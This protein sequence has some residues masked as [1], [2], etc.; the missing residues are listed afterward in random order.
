MLSGWRILDLTDH[1]GEVGP[2]LLADL[3]AEVVKVEPQGGCPSRAIGPAEV[4]FSAYNGNKHSIELSGDRTVDRHRLVELLTSVDVVVESGPPGLLAEHGLDRADIVGANPHIVSVI[5]TP[6]GRSGPRAD[7]P[8]TELTI[9][10]LG[11]SIRLQ[12]TRERAPVQMSVPQVWRHAG[13]EAAVAAMVASRRMTTT[14][15]PQFVDVSAQSAMTWT[16]LNAMEAY[17]VQGQEFE[18]NGSELHLSI[19]VQL[20]IEA[21]DGYVVGVPTGRTLQH[22]APWLVEEGI[23]G[24]EWADVDWAT[25]DHRVIAG[26]PTTH[27]MAEVADAIYTL[28]RRYP[29]WELFRRSLSYGASLAPLNTLTDLLGFDHLDAR[30]FWQPGDASNGDSD[31]ARN[32]GAFYCRNGLRPPVRRGRTELDGAPDETRAP[33]RLPTDGPD[34]AP[35]RR[36]GANGESRE[37]ELPLAGVKVVDFSWIGVGPITAKSLADHGATV[38]RVESENRLDGLRMQPPYVGGESGL[39]RSNFFGTFNTSKL[40]LSLDLKT[41]AGIDVARRL[42]GWADVVVESFTPGTFDRLGLGYAEMSAAHPSLI[43]VSTSMLGAGSPASTMAGYGYHAAAIAGF[44]NLVGWPDLPPDG[45]WLAYTDTIG[46]RFITTALLAALDHRRRTGEGSHLEAAQLEVALQLL[47]PELAEFQL[48]GDEPRRRGNRDPRMAPQGVYPVR[49]DDEWLA[50]S[51]VDDDAWRRFVDVLG[52]PAW[53]LD[54]AL[55]TAAGRQ[56]HHDRIDAHLTEWTA[57]RD[58]PEAEQL[59]RDYGIAAGVVQSSRQLSD[60]P[61]YHHRRFYHYLEH[62]EVGV[63][64]YAGH[65]YRI[66]GYDHGPRHAA[67]CLGEHTYEVLT[68]LLGLDPDEV[69]AIAAADALL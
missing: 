22:I 52:R 7:Q 54:P 48:T 64:P 61:Q 44:Q 34:R 37:P 49:G 50:V 40:G 18:R 20:R 67:P 29:K 39:N 46:P 25:F 16:L 68:E 8:A 26:E 21:A 60:D 65:Q 36:A 12:G 11:G 5:V 38:V 23:V 1:R 35:A 14:G 31:P 62:S 4:A 59:L 2:F 53:A 63:V 15:Q 56:Q 13:A 66:E 57:D 17:E 32:P 55:E 58:G 28:C 9:G 33:V 47:A 42:I 43:M 6:F 24:Q 19:A 10:A 30:S 27:S 51:I 3:G 69:G 45:P 41:P